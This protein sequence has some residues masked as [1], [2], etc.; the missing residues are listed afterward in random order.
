[1]KIQSVY[2]RSFG[3]LKDFQMDFNCNFNV[4]KQTNGFGKTTLCHFIRAMLYGFKYT[5]TK[6]GGE[7]VSDAGV[8]LAWG[9]AEKIGGNLLVKHEGATYLIERYFGATGK[10]ETLSVTNHVT[11]EKLPI[12]EVGEYFLGLTAD[13]FDRSTYF[14]QESVELSTT[15]NFDTRLAGLVQ[16]AENFA[17]VESCLKEYQNN[18]SSTR[19][20][21][22][23]IP[24]AQRDKIR[25]M[26]E[27]ADCENAERR[28]ETI[29]K[30]LKAIDA[31]KLRLQQQIEKDA[32]RQENLQKQIVRC[33]RTPE[34]IELAQKRDQLAQQLSRIGKN[35]DEDKKRCDQL[36]EKIRNTPDVTTKQRRICKPMLI[37]GLLLL[38]AGIGLAF[39]QVVVGI[40]AAVV[41]V[42]LAAISFVVLKPLVTLQAGEKDAY[43]SDYYKIAE[44]YVSCAGLDFDQVQKCLWEKYNQYVGDCRQLEAYQNVVVN[45]Q[46]TTQMEEDLHRVVQELQRA[47]TNLSNLSHEA[48]LLQGESQSLKL[49]SIAAREKLQAVETRLQEAQRQSDVATETLKLLLQAKE[50]LSVSYLPKLKNTCQQLLNQITDGNYELSLDR[51]FNLYLKTNGITK[52]LDFYSRGIR[53]IT[54]LCFRVAL[55]SMLF[56]DNIPLL[57]V[58]DAFVNFDEEN[59]ARAIKLLKTLSKNTQIIYLTCH[60]RLGN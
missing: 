14:P 2:I 57:I 28:K 13:S 6:R 45:Q 17:S 50:N 41:G 56:N 32:Q 53:E 51:N 48:G 29:D 5:R 27:I 19:R 43:I 54:L 44:N 18:L 23:V 59:F 7:N 47:R 24:S 38:A 39:W 12:T 15:E 33:Q 49:D 8:W 16:N 34:Q 40:V 42:A 4:L 26:R 55:S 10:V 31:D 36:A 11:G 52:S 22:A 25:L 9:S 60:D 3:K 58:D 20:A 30:R 1:M 46:D 37:A 21:D 35:F